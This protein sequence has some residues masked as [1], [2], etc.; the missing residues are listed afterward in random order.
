MDDKAPGRGTN[1]RR[2]H[3]ST[4]A[5]AEAARAICVYPSRGAYTA[6]L[7]RALAAERDRLA[8]DALAA[9][10]QAADAYDAQLKAEAERDRLREALRPFADIGIGTNPDYQPIIR[11]DRDAILRARAAL[12]SKEGGE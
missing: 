3:T 12:A 8:L 5:V 2:T 1:D 9:Q 10:G 11:M 7:L 4:E 6:N